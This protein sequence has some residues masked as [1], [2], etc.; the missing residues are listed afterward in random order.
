[1]T[2][3]AGKT[4][5][6]RNESRRPNTYGDPYDAKDITALLNEEIGEDRESA[7]AVADVEQNRVHMDDA[8]TAAILTALEE[9]GVAAESTEQT[10]LLK[11]QWWVLTLH[12]IG[13]DLPHLGFDSLL[14]L[15][16]QRVRRHYRN[17]GKF[18]PSRIDVYDGDDEI[19]ATHDIED[20]ESDKPG[21]EA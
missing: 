16:G 14:T 13:D 5:S 12:W 7:E 6:N 8:D 9:L 1:M 17:H 11:T 18:G 15:L 20:E 4:L 10:T 19:V 3:I 21:N 2:R